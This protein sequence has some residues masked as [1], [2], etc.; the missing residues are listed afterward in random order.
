MASRGSEVAHSSTHGFARITSNTLIDARD[1]RVS[2]TKRD[3]GGPT[4]AEGDLQKSDQ[5]HL[6]LRCGK[7][8]P[9]SGGGFPLLKSIVGDTR[10]THRHDE[11]RKA[12]RRRGDE[13]G[14]KS[15]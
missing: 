5:R 10:D 12:R 9:E 15:I 3:R 11:M 4:P 8:L 13:T 7:T 2:G 1:R 6:V 14:T